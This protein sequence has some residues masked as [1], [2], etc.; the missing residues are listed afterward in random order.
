MAEMITTDRATSLQA[1]MES[2]EIHDYPVP[3]HLRVKYLIDFFEEWEEDMEIARLEDEM[4]TEV[5]AEKVT[6]QMR[7]KR[8]RR[9]L[10]RE[11]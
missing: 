2:W 4:L 5:A 8:F 3:M 9:N 7:A 1:L 11:E 6:Q 10:T